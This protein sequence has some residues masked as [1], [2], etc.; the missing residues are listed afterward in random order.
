MEAVFSPRLLR[1]DLRLVDAH[2]LGAPLADCQS[3]DAAHDHK[4]R[5]RVVIEEGCT[6]MLLLFAA[7]MCNDVLVSPGVKEKRTMPPLRRHVCKSAQVIRHK[8]TVH[9][10]PF[11][12]HKS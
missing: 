4:I 11:A 8:C 3:R 6:K 1:R 7:A 2:E 10:T 9:I 12:K 5:E